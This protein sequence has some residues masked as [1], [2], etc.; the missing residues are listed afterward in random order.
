MLLPAILQE[1]MHYVEKAVECCYKKGINIFSDWN[2]SERAETVRTVM[3]ELVNASQATITAIWQIESKLFERLGR[4]GKK[5]PPT[6]VFVSIYFKKNRAYLQS[7][8]ILACYGFVNPSASLQRMVYESIL[9]GY[10][11]IVEPN[12]AMLLYAKTDTEL[13]DDVMAAEQDRSLGKGAVAGKIYENVRDK[14]LYS[15]LCEMSHPGILG[16]NQD[17]PTLNFGEIESNLKTGL[18]LSY[19]SIQMLSEVFMDR[20]NDE[21]KKLV[22]EIMQNAIVNADNQIPTI[23]PD[24]PSYKSM[25]KLK[26][27]N[28]LGIL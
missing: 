16:V 23:E 24:K 19:G 6:D 22:K 2:L 27:G 13:V 5:L 15:L 9:R 1:I 17:F 21:L 10:Y 18:L 4:I 26:N 25:L 8:H 20:Y 3:P 11:F 12:Q 7:A 14:K 28:F